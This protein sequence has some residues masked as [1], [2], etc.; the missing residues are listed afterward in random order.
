MRETV[1]RVKE[2]P[3]K[4]GRFLSDKG[5]HLHVSKI[6]IWISVV[7]LEEGGSAPRLAGWL[8]IRELKEI[9]GSAARNGAPNY[10]ECP[11][12]QSDEASG[13]CLCLGRCVKVWAVAGGRDCALLVRLLEEYR[14]KGT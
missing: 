8:A 4:S 5:H 3:D 1:L 2:L 7:A 10:T 13:L 11:P 14:K 6:P 9:L 12:G